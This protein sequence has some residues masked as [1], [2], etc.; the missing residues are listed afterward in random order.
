MF[1]SENNKKEFIEISDVIKVVQEENNYFF[2]IIIKYF[3]HDYDAS[4]LFINYFET[5]HIRLHE[6]LGNDYTCDKINNLLQDIFLITVKYSFFKD[7]YNIPLI[8]Y[9]Y[10]QVFY[11]NKIKTK[12]DELVEMNRFQDLIIEELLKYEKERHKKNICECGIDETCFNDEKTKE[13]FK[14]FL[15]YY[16]VTNQ[17]NYLNKDNRLLN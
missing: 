14:D 4:M 6:I 9:N 13:L 5:S 11:Y 12:I 8:Y 7:N 16:F 1:T 15:D 10:K 2:K 3:T 17:K